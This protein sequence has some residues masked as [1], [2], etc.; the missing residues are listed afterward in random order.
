MKKLALC[1]ALALVSLNAAADVESRLYAGMNLYSGSG[2]EKVDWDDAGITDSTK[3]HIET[4]GGSLRAGYIFASNNRFE[5]SATTIHADFG[6]GSGEEFPGIDFDWKFTLN[7]ESVTP[8]LGIGFGLYNYK[9][10][11]DGTK[12]GNK[13]NGVA[14]N[15]MAGL[16][17][18]L[19]EHVEFDIS[20]L[21]KG[22]GWEEVK[23]EDELGDTVTAD[24]GESMTNIQIGVSYLF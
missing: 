11:E 2:S 13:V 7:E 19:H 8:Y 16:A 9:D 4:S 23:F 12:N 17:A 10:L 20:V 6:E 3:E 15:L 18:Q 14:F 21:F 22:I 24:A 1:S 5:I